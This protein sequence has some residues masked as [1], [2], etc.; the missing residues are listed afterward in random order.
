VRDFASQS[1]IALRP[2]RARPRCGVV[3]TH[4]NGHQYIELLPVVSGIIPEVARALSHHRRSRRLGAHLTRTSASPV[5][6]GP[7]GAWPRSSG[8]S[9]S[10]FCSDA[11]ARCGASD[12][13]YGTAHAAASSA[14]AAPHVDASSPGLRRSACIRGSVLRR[15]RSR[16]RRR[17]EDPLSSFARASSIVS[18]R[19]TDRR[20]SNQHVDLDG[21]FRGT[22][23]RRTALQP[24]GNDCR[25]ELF[26]ACRFVT[27]GLLN[28]GFHRRRPFLEIAADHFSMS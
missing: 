19:A 12:A 6:A 22:P 24:N 8:C 9:R 16:G 15:R 13:Y 14:A 28:D 3:P 27:F 18:C 23:P 17:L 26:A 10:I 20:V 21:S 25:R 5:S 1:A 2:D 4:L 7:S 11:A